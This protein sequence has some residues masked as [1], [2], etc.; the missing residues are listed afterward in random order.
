MRGDDW[1][2]TYTGRRFW[3]SDPDPAEIDIV[4]IAHALSM[5]C[6][7]GGHCRRFY[8][9]AEH[10]VL[11][12]SAVRPKDQRWALMH[13]AAEAYLVDLPRPVK[14]QMPAYRAMEDAILRAIAVRFGLDGPIPDA[15]HEADTRLLA[16]ERNQI[17][18]RCE[19]DWPGLRGVV[20][21]GGM[22]V[23]WLPGEARSRFLRAFMELFPVGAAA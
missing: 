12:S 20:P 13:D 7:F 1:V 22:I 14:R 6:R 21:L 5:Q 19:A 4:D 10:S 16:E 3:P 18:V 17:M 15:V 9:V 8:S 2:Q 23:G 11:L